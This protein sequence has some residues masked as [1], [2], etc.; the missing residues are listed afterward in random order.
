MLLWCCC[1]VD[2]AF[3]PFLHLCDGQG[4]LSLWCRCTFFWLD[5]LYLWPN[6]FPLR[7]A[8]NYDHLAYMVCTVDV[9]MATITMIPSRGYCD[10]CEKICQKQCLPVRGDITG[11]MC[12][13]TWKL[14]SRGGGQGFQQL[15]GHEG[16]YPHT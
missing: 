9:L 10:Q 12:H 5:L 4:V 13:N 16:M 8:L 2:T 6:F 1:G 14:P 3:E 11:V 7:G 15:T